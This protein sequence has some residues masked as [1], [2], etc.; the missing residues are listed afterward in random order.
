MSEEQK[1][2]PAYKEDSEEQQVVNIIVANKNSAHAARAYRMAQNDLNYDYYHGRS[3]QNHKLQGQSRE[4]LPKMSMAVEQVTSFLHQGLMDVGR[5][6]SASASRGNKQPIFT[7]SEVEALMEKWLEDAKFYTHEQDGIKAA[8]LGSLKITK[9][10]TRQVP[11]PKYTVRRKREALGYSNELRM[12]KDTETQPC[13]SLV[14]QKD[15]FPDPTG[16]K[17]YEIERIEMDYHTLVEIARANP[18]DYDMVEIERLGMALTSGPDYDE[19]AKARET[20]QNQ[21][22]HESRLRVQMHEFW[23]TLVDPQG[24]VIMENC[25][26]GVVNDLYLVRKPMKNPLWHQRSPYNATPLI[27]VPW[28]EWHKCLMDAPQQLNR[29]Q[30][31]LFNLIL[32]S[33]LGAVFGIKQVRMNYLLNPDELSAGLAPNAVVKVGPQCPPGAKAVET[34]STSNGGA[35]EALEASNMVSSEFNSAS[36]TNDL[37]MGV[38]P[39]R[40]VKATEVVESSNSITGTFSSIAKAVELDGVEPVLYLIFAT[41]MQEIKKFSVPEYQAILGE[42]KCQQLDRISA[43]K[44]FALTVQ[45]HKFRV[46]GLTQTLNKIKDFRKVTTLL[47]TISGSP[48]LMDEFLKKYSI[49][50]LLSVIMKS[51]DIDEDQIKLD[52]V[53][54]LMGQVPEQGAP[55]QNANAQSP[56]GAGPQGMSQVPQAAGIKPDAA[57]AMD[58]AT[59]LQSPIPGGPP[60]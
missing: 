42:D 23:G 21:T 14:R 22:L 28:S 1:P 46:F 33:G 37:R 4:F 36:L 39:S 19:R 59:H 41:M 57:H 55:G 44:R 48:Q 35:Q 52:E 53:E 29:A 24:K 27:R 3:D 51:L 17:L 54:E 45:G 50:K 16:S 34:V 13:L 43:E 58:D 15:W 8:L 5:W 10:T 26:A 60:K 18:D 6:F 9:V 20:G 12:S 40:S 49:V 32:D 30:N 25:V 11:K 47:Q 31:E 2:G 56:Q 7:D 38:L